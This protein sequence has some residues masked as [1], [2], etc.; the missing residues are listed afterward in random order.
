M[1]RRIETFVLQQIVKIELLNR[2]VAESTYHEIWM[3]YSEVSLYCDGN[4]QVYGACNIRKVILFW[5]KD[6]SK[7]TLKK[8]CPFR[9]FIIKLKGIFY[10]GYQNKH[11][12]EDIVDI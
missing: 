3:T 10:L 8:M 4:C 5:Q 9:T 12:P 1:F 7:V 11:Y 6:Q 2:R